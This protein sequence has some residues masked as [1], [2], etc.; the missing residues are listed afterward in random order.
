MA[1]ARAA[2]AVSASTALGAQGLGEWRGQ[3]KL[4]R[5]LRKLL[6]L[7]KACCSCRVLR[8]RGRLDACAPAPPPTHPPTPRAT[9]SLPSLWRLLLPAAGVIPPNATLVFD[10]SIV[11]NFTVFCSRDIFICTGRLLEKCMER[12]I[13]PGVPLSL[14]Q[15]ELLRLE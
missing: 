3:A 6:L 4:V 10:V 14:M 13:Y 12:T 1:M 8:G 2:R 11:V 5:Q 15:V 9:H 7:G